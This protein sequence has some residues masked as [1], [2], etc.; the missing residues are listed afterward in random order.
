MDCEWNETDEKVFYSCVCVCVW[1][2]CCI[3]FIGGNVADVFRVQSMLGKTK[4]FHNL[5]E[6]IAKKSRQN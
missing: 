5:L 3:T 2:F 6:N 1:L 4:L